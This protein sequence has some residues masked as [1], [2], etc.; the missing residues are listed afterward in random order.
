MKSEDESRGVGN[1]KLTKSK[2]GLRIIPINNTARSPFELKEPT[3]S[4][5]KEVRDDWQLLFSQQCVAGN[6]ELFP[7]KQSCIPI[8]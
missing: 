1:K 4:P 2:S 6:G 7:L 5:D 8:F 3:W